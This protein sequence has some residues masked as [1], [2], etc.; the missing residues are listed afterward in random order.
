MASTGTVLVT[1]PGRTTPEANLVDIPVGSIIETADPA[2]QASLT[3]ATN[4]N[5]RE[6][7]ASVQLYGRTRLQVVQA[8]TPRYSLGVNPYRIQLL[9]SGGRVRVS[10]S[11]APSREVAVRVQSEPG[12]LTL[13]D[14]PGSYA[15]FDVTPTETVV[16]V[17]EGVATVIAQ[18][19][20]VTLLREQRAEVAA[21]SPPR[22]PLPAERNLIVNGDFQQPLDV[23]WVREVRQPQDPEEQWGAAEVVTVAGRRAVHLFRSG[24]NWGEVGVTQEIN[25]DVR[26][27]TS[28]RLQFDLLISLQDLFNCGRLGTEC[29]VMVKIRYVDDR[30]AER[31]WLQGFYYNFNPD[32]NIPRGCPS[33]AIP[34]AEHERVPSAQWTFYESDN[35]LEVF[36]AAGYPPVT[37]RSVTFYASGHTFDS[38]VRD[39]QLLATE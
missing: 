18:N 20:G 22:G 27:Y 31:E 38:R 15:S 36:R 17:R 6:E 25:R 23:G 39:V 1:R 28:L 9:V 10:L 33:C 5:G 4:L 16:T 37:I 32:P 35:L 12:A 13:L 3:F 11:L 7:L 21:N 34:V 2:A 8:D 26:D 24:Q 14:S 30:G 19:E 29:P